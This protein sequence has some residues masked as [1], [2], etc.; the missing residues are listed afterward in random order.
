[1]QRIR[2]PVEDV[3]EQEVGPGLGGGV[4][5]DR[6]KVASVVAHL[7]GG[8]ERTLVTLAT[9]KGRNRLGVLVVEVPNGRVPRDPVALEVGRGDP[10]QIA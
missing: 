3:A 9:K 6:E 7:R 4:A 2:H 1:M 8:P 10:F 5:Q